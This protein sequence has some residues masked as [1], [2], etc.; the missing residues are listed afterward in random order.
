MRRGFKEQAKQ[1]ALEIRDEIGLDAYGP[2]NPEAL[3]EAYGI[4]VYQI[5]DLGDHGCS[6]EALARFTDDS[7]AT[8]SA[9]LLPVG[10]GR[11]IL[12]NDSHA[13]TRRRANIAHEMAHHLLE[14]DFAAAILGPDGC[15]DL[16]PDL[17][18]EAT[19][20]AGELLVPF[21]A[22]LLMARR[23][24]SDVAVAAKYEISPKLAAMRLNASGARRIVARQRPSRPA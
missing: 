6:D 24:A 19:W 13:P 11:V 20:F 14:H 18:D 3:A 17:E 7:R 1:H 15:R 9:A 8:F 5:S 12:D 10:T 21:K 16:A 23:N 22:A 2:L 4:P